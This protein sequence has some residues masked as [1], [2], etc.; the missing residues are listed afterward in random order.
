MRF[1]R[2]V[3]LPKAFQSTQQWTLHSLLLGLLLATPPQFLHASIK[4]HSRNA[5]QPL[6]AG[7]CASAQRLPPRGPQ[8]SQHQRASSRNNSLKAACSARRNSASPDLR[9]ISGTLRPSRRSIRSSRSSNVHPI[10]SAKARPTLLLPAPMKPIRTMARVSDCLP[11]E[12]A[13]AKHTNPSFRRALN[14]P[15]S[16]IRF[17]LRFLYCFSERFLR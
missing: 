2:L 13:F 17:S 8:S 15:F 10:C 1:P 6:P 16:P 4:E 11:N 7:H 9:K 3:K 5:C 12:C 14:R